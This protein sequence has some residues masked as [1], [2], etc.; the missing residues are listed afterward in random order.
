MRFWRGISTRSGWPAG[1]RRRPSRYVCVRA[2]MLD[3]A[4]TDRRI[5]WTAGRLTG[6]RWL[7]SKTLTVT[8][9]DVLSWR[10]CWLDDDDDAAAADDAWAARAAAWAAARATEREAQVADLLELLAADGGVM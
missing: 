6:P 8:V 9:E 5:A 1:S 10:P 4:W 3:I 2:M 7:V